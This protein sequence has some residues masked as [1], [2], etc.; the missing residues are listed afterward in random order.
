MRLAFNI[1]MSAS[2]I[3]DSEGRI[4][5]A[6]NAFTQLVGISLEDLY[7]RPFKALIAEGPD[8]VAA[9]R[10]SAREKDLTGEVREFGI[11]LKRADETGDLGCVPVCV[12]GGQIHASSGLPIYVLK[13]RV[14]EGPV[15]KSFNDE[16]RNLLYSEAMRAARLGYWSFDFETRRCRVSAALAQLIGIRAPAEEQVVR[17]SEMLASTHPDDL[18]RW[19]DAFK[20]VLVQSKPRLDCDIRIGSTTFGWRWVQVRGEVTER[21]PQTQY[22]RRLSGFVVDIDGRRRREMEIKATETLMRDALYEAGFSSW[23]IN[24]E[25]GVGY[26]SGRLIE[27]LFGREGLVA[28]SR[29]GL[30]ARLPKECQEHFST[31]WLAVIE[32]GQG[33]FAYCG[34]LISDAGE[35]IT[36]EMIGRPI[37]FDPWGR[38][39]RLAGYMREVAGAIRSS[40]SCCR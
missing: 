27:R 23:V 11:A 1:S 38:P 35:R 28:V 37:R 34:D 6:N 36:V 20:A 8:P 32:G 29:E 26:F 9:I 39:E 3:L 16:T 31:L 2:V 15:Q 13:F 19:R 40:A 21:D 10:A 14:D 18:G 12:R 22:V 4:E 5:D 7:G 33:Q 30:I 24:R 25:E 17:E